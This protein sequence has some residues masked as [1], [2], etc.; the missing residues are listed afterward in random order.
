MYINAVVKQNVLILIQGALIISFCTE[1]DCIP[2]P[3]Q[4][5][6]SVIVMLFMPTSIG[7]T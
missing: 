4:Y 6:T 7:V 3:K 5:S 1:G 2:L